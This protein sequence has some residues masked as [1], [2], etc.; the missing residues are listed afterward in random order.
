MG[1]FQLWYYWLTC[2]FLCMN[3]IN[4]IL[5]SWITI[6]PFEIHIFYKCSYDEAFKVW[7]TSLQRYACSYGIDKND[8]SLALRLKQLCCCCCERISHIKYPY[9]WNAFSPKWNKNSRSDSNE[10]YLWLGSQCSLQWI[11][12]Q[13]V[14][15][16]DLQW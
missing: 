3:W 2:V 5:I 12:R 10:I 15:T 9:S 1:S 7:N 13:V 8:L 14:I 4:F 11:I 16:H 6:C